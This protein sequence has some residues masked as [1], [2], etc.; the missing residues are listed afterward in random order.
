MKVKMFT[1]A[2]CVYCR[3]QKKFFADKGV[4]FEEAH[5]DQ[6]QAALE[7]MVRLSGQYG[8]PFT[9][10]T[11]DDGKLEGVLGFDQPRLAQLLGV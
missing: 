9:V 6:D 11:K 5:V 7:E 3:A 4:A 8:V 10:V 1:T 2:T